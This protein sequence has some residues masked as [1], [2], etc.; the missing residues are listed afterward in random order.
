MNYYIK[1]KKQFNNHIDYDE[2]PCFAMSAE[3]NV[4]RYHDG[5]VKRQHQYPPVPK[6]LL[7]TVMEKKKLGFLGCFSFVLRKPFRCERKRL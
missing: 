5:Y 3:R 6:S 2:I 1:N 7:V 4:V